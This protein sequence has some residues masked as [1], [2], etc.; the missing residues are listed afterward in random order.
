M[1]WHIV[2]KYTHKDWVGKAVDAHF[3]SNAVEAMHRTAQGPIR[4]GELLR[5]YAALNEPQRRKAIQLHEQRLKAD[6]DFELLMGHI[7]EGWMEAQH[8][9][10][11]RDS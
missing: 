7:E 3:V 9:K 4:P 8:K 2:V 1:N 11:F 5:A 10:V 6:R